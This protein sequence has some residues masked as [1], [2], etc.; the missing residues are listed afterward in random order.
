MAP[1]QPNASVAATGLGIRYIG[2][3]AYAYSGSV[4]ITSGGDEMLNFTSGAGIIKAEFQVNYPSNNDE[5]MTYE[6]LF[7]NISIQKWL[8]TGAQTPYQPQ[9]PVKLII[10]P[11]TIVVLSATSSGSSRSQIASMTG[12]VYGAE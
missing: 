11:F 8:N 2:N 1:V 10:P 4:S 6:I 5:D 3:Y 7:S 9:N 12:R